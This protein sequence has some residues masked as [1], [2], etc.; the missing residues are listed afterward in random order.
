MN[1]PTI[2]NSIGMR[3]Q[4]IPTGEFMMGTP[5]S[6]RGGRDNIQHRVRITQPFYLGVYEVTQVEYEQV[7]GKNPS[8]FHALADHDTK[9]FPV[10]MVTWDAAIDFCKRL[11]SQ[12]EERQAGHTYRLPTEAEWEYACRAGSTTEFCYG[13]SLSS[14]QANFDGFLPYGKAS[15]GP[16]LQRP[17]VVGSYPANEFGI[18]DMHGNVY[19]WCADKYKKDYYQD[20]PVNDPQGP[21]LGEPLRVLRG[22]GWNGIARLCRSADRYYDV[23]T[24][25]YND[26]GFRVALTPP[27]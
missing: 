17:A 26:Y 4:S 3:L 24:R 14:R 19:E 2:V 25:T 15:R 18:F 27:P 23:P 10:E 20:S 12:A 8:S 6:R 1:S 13:D 9:R 11:S 21:K 16:N 22:G 7:M 5:K